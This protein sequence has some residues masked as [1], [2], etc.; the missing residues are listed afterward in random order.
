MERQAHRQSL[1]LLRIALRQ[2]EA[3]NKIIFGPNSFDT[4][5]S[6]IAQIE[7]R[8]DTAFEAVERSYQRER[9]ELKKQLVAPKITLKPIVHD[10]Q[11]NQY[12]SMDAISEGDD[13]RLIGYA[14]AEHVAK[15]QGEME[16]L[17]RLRDSAIDHSTNMSD[18]IDGIIREALPDFPVEI[19][20]AVDCVKEL[21]RQLKLARERGQ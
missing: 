5:A 10:Y 8:M 12:V 4:L 14:P 13:V 9:D 15:I 20:S 11:R 2:I 21:A 18:A 7:E 6:V 16:Q 3:D 17:R 19:V 1:I